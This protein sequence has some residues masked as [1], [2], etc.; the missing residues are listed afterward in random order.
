M[1]SR[2]DRVSSGFTGS[3]TLSYEKEVSCEL[4]ASRSVLTFQSTR[5]SAS[6][7]QSTPFLHSSQTK[8]FKSSTST[9]AEAVTLKGLDKT[10]KHMNGV[11]NHSE[12]TFFR[13]N[14]I[15]TILLLRKEE[16]LTGFLS[17]SSFFVVFWKE[18][19]WWWKA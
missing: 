2:L 8:P 1:N 15:E 7:P 11:I 12:R 6:A 14:R 19:A 16:W 3:G 10:P 4:S 17:F 13:G 18:C 9:S 5:S